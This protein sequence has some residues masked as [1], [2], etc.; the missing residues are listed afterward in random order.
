[1]LILACASLIA[2]VWA[3]QSSWRYLRHPNPYRITV[4]C[5]G[6]FMVLGI[7]LLL[8]V[9]LLGSIV[10]WLLTPTTRLVV[11][12]LFNVCLMLSG[13][14]A[15]L[16]GDNIMD[17]L[18]SRSARRKRRGLT[19]Y[20]VTTLTLMSVFLV[21]ALVMGER[22]T[23]DWFLVQPSHTLDLVMLALTN[24]LYMTVIYARLFQ[25]Y[26]F[27]S[28][29]SLLASF[30]FGVLCFKITC[31]LGWANTILALIALGTPA[32]TPLAHLLTTLFA[33]T[34]LCFLLVF[35]LGVR[36]V[37]SPSK[38]IT[39]FGERMW[40]YVT[41]WRLYHLWKV[42]TGVIP[43]VVPPLKVAWL[44]LLIDNS[45]LRDARIIEILGAMQRLNVTLSTQEVQAQWIPSVE[46]LIEGAATRESPSQ[47]LH[48][49]EQL[50]LHD[51]RQLVRAIRVY[52]PR[53][54]QHNTPVAVLTVLE[55]PPVF[56]SQEVHYLELVAQAFARIYR[57]LAEGEPQKEAM[58]A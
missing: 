58:P 56:T 29:V 45:T 46:A 40:S 1:M 21:R 16:Y 41:V 4:W 35:Y 26:R 32:A 28:K 25:F 52:T 47:H 10:P 48:L 7:L 55:H 23:V 33:V 3:I 8:Y 15:V 37:Q 53:V 36:L 27:C 50:A 43:H 39:Q 49:V 34:I 20:L 24:L 22:E 13:Y 6:I 5:S 17:G 54:P 38:R 9:P 44:S 12:T 30:S 31:V 19:L 14:C 18:A 42:L 57:A 51:A 2:L 11:H